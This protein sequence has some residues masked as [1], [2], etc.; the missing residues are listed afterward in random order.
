[1]KSDPEP[2]RTFFADLAQVRVYGSATDAARAAASDAAQWIERAIATNTSA[3]ILAATGSSQIEFVESLTAD[4]TIP[5]KS[6]DV[7]HLDEYIGLDAAHPASFRRWI[8]TRIEE[9]A[10]PRSVEYIHGD[11]AA[12]EEEIGRYASLLDQ[13]PIDVAFAGFGENG[14]LAFNDPGEARFDDPANVKQ[15]TLDEECRRQQ[16]GEGHFASLEDVPTSAITVTC[17]C[18]FRAAAWVCVVPDRRKAAAV[19]AALEGPISEACP[20]SLARRHPNASVYLDLESASLLTW[21]RD[22]PRS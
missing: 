5:W 12:S 21:P 18:L 10:H 7:F 20:A 15:V 22:C 4:P 14:H 9:T 8:K 17:S 16:A 19:R 11:A 1:M 2:I 3:R 6:V 13:A